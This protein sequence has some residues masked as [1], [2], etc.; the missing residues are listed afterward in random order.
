MSHVPCA[1]LISIVL[2]SASAVQAQERAYVV[3][4]VSLD[5]ALADH[6]SIAGPDPSGHAAGGSVRAGSAIRRGVGVELEW[7]WSGARHA[8]TVV[9]PIGI[10][11]P[12][13][14]GIDLPIVSTAVTSRVRQS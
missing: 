4:A 5:E 2:L 13:V 8:A 6:S 9:S 1:A 11:S 14:G 12:I 10:T 3:G 7:A